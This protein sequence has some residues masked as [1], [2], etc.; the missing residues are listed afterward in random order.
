[1]R[2]ISS[3]AASTLTNKYKYNG[4]EFNNDFDLNQYDAFYRTLDPQIGR[5]HQIDPKVESTENW[6]SYAAM[7]DNPIRY[8]DHLGD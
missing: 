4:I 8:A 5:F 7:L 6:S 1:M 2:G 3:K